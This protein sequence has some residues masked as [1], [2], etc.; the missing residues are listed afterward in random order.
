MDTH[1]GTGVAVGDAAILGGVE[2][3]L[4]MGAPCLVVGTAVPPGELNSGG[5]EGR[6]GKSG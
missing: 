6:E 3:D 4:A 5:N 2:V 1:M